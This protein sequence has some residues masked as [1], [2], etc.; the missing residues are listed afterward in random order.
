MLADAL[1]WAAV[2]AIAAAVV[3]FPRPAVFWSLGAGRPFVLTRAAF[4]TVRF[5]QAAPA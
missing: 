2:A 1:R 3:R 5:R 4:G